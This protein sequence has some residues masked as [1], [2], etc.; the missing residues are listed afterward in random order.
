MTTFI[1]LK[2]FGK[3]QLSRV[4][5]SWE[6]SGGNF[7]VC[8]HNGKDIYE[9]NGRNKFFEWIRPQVSEED[10]EIIQSI[11]SMGGKLELESSMREFLKK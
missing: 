2:D 6:I 7:N 1:S 10:F 11:I 9:S 3:V 5:A 4:L 8:F